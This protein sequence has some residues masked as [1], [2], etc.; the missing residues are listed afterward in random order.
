MILSSCSGGTQANAATAAERA[1]EILGRAPRGLAAEVIKRGSLTIAVAADLPPLSYTDK[2][3]K[4][5]GFDVEVGAE[6]ARQLGLSHELVTPMVEV[7]PE[8]LKQGRADMAVGAIPRG[9]GLGLISVS[10]PYYYNKGRLLV[11]EGA[12]PLSSVDGQRVGAAIQSVFYEWLRESSGALA[13]SYPSDADAITALEAGRVQ[14]VLTDALTA[15]SAIEEGKRVQLSGEPLL[16]SPVRFAVKEGER[17]LLRLCNATIASLRESG[18]LSSAS[19]AWFSGLDLARPTL[20]EAASPV[21][22]P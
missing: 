8:E 19:R 10:A 21:P 22:S 14:A 4:L 1:R 7:I 6:V 11:K 17:D 15:E 12:A 16:A 18:W 2:D 13:V 3:G 9:A 20:T 5:T